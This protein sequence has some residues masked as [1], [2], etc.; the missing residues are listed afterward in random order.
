MMPEEIKRLNYYDQQFLREPDFTDEQEYHKNMRRRL[1]RSLHTT[2]VVKG[3][4]VTKKNDQEIT[5]SAPGMALDGAGREIV[6]PTSQDI[7]VDVTAAGTKFVTIQYTEEQTEPPPPEYMISE[8]D[9]TRWTESSLIEVLD[10]APA[11]PGEQLILG[12]VN[13]TSGVIQEPIEEGIPP[14]HRRMSGAAGKML[15]RD[16]KF[17]ESDWVNIDLEAPGKIRISGSLGSLSIEDVAPTLTIKKTDNTQ[18]SQLRFQNS[19]GAYTANLHV[20]GEMNSGLV[21]RVGPANIDPLALPER[22]TITSGGHIGIGT[23]IPN[24]K[25][26]IKGT[27][28][29]NDAKIII[30]GEGDDDET[31]NFQ[32]QNTQTAVIGW[33]SGDGV[34]KLKASNNVAGA[35]GINIRSGGN[36][37]IGTIDPSAKL[38]VRGALEFST[39]G[40]DRNSIKFTR[41]ILHHN[42]YPPPGISD[43]DSVDT[44]K[45]SLAVQSLG[46]NDPTYSLWIGHQYYEELQPGLPYPYFSPKL[47]LKSDGSARLQGDLSVYN[48]QIRS[49]SKPGFV[50]DYFIN[51]TGDILE[52]GDVVILGKGK[53]SNFWATGNDIPIPEVDLSDK[54]YDTRVCGIVAKVVTD[55]SLPFVEGEW[56]EQMVFE[57]GGLQGEKALKG[58]TKKQKT[59]SIPDH[60]LKKFAAK[61]DKKLNQTKVQDKQIGMMVTMGAYAYCKVDATIASI[62]V[63]DLLTTSP[64]KG[65]AQKVLEPEKAI[66]G[67]IGKALGSLKKGKGKIPVLVMLQ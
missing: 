41:E 2:G 49:G 46:E 14:N 57:G 34:L 26:H 18:L 52:Q 24:T 60:P 37:G 20:T 42:I 19:G 64:T 50:V 22:L 7:L 27:N 62:E 40:A 12:I 39:D 16:P 23:E 55:Q 21:L 31:I 8:A 38:D 66:G 67:I 51:F 6:L 30:E 4:V 13:I 32:T 15:I 63:G 3:L 17:S 47:L 65:H 28:G 5:I 61:S 25:L 9:R 10:A 59:P 48:L 56:T 58:K 45:L 43:Y 29:A 36:V 35:E 53:I 1:N 11:D 33:D 44:F 54:G